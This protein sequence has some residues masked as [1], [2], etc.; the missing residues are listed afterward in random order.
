[1][2]DESG[3]SKALGA[4][5]VA[6]AVGNRVALSVRGLHA[7][8]APWALLLDA[9]K[10][11]L[12]DGAGDALRRFRRNTNDFGY[13]YTLLCL[14]IAA[15]CVLTKPF[16]LVVI[17]A[18]GALW[19]YVYHFRNA[20]MVVRGVTLNLR[21]QGLLLILFSFLVLYVLTDVSQILM[22][23]L[24]GGVFACVA[25]AVLRVPEPLPDDGGERG[26]AG[27][28]SRMRSS[29]GEGPWAAPSDDWEIS[30]LRSGRRGSIRHWGK[31]EST[32]R[33]SVPVVLRPSKGTR[34]ESASKKMKRYS[35]RPLRLEPH[36]HL[37]ELAVRKVIEQRRASHDASPPTPVR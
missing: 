3:K 33:E 22:G 15:F 20:D 21:A 11:A 1:M 19:G 5:G 2:D 36:H 24:T 4:V 25:H 13:N 37:A 10:F 27:G 12:P 32:F 9:R 14:V 26:F 28:D 7:R 23:G 29:R 31:W 16:S 8:S 18:L 6:L 30:Y 34:R 35:S 17:A